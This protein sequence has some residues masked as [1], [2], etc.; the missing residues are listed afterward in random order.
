MSAALKKL[1]INYAAG[2]VRNAWSR[3]A[4]KDS[5]TAFASWI[6]VN[7]VRKTEASE[8]AKELTHIDSA[9][10][11]LMLYL[12]ILRSSNAFYNLWIPAG[13]VFWEGITTASDPT[14]R[15]VIEIIGEDGFNAMREV[16]HNLGILYEKVLPAYGK[17]EAE[18]LVANS[19]PWVD[20][21]KANPRVMMTRAADAFDRFAAMVDGLPDDE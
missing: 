14:K 2:S 15:S 6:A 4:P 18:G 12:E 1:G 13:V 8:A 17:L 7:A 5:A 21:A 11:A 3:G 10:H 16:I 19:Q 20:A 9:Q